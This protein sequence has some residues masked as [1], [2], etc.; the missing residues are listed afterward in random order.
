MR[1]CS[2]SG[3][4][5]RC[6]PRGPSSWYFGGRESRSWC[7]L[8][9]A[10][11]SGSAI[12]GSSHLDAWAASFDLDEDSKCWKCY[13]SRRDGASSYSSDGCVGCVTGSHAV[14]YLEIGCGCWCGGEGRCL[15]S[16][17]TGAVSV[18]LARPWS[19]RYCWKITHVKVWTKDFSLMSLW[20]FGRKMIYWF[21]S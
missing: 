7:Q 5:A 3:T 11:W 15:S 8:D 21:K 17:G 6:P 13:A 12:D 19:S 9:D 14:R 18:R 10:R 2:S 4:D 1:S 16:A 20:F